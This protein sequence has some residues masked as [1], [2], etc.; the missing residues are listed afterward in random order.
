[1]EQNVNKI[2]ITSIPQSFAN[3]PDSYSSSSGP[4]KGTKLFSQNENRLKCPFLYSVIKS[5]LLANFLKGKLS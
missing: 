1:M 4:K 3:G 5:F 2:S